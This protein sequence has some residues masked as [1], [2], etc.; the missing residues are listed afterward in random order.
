MTTTAADSTD[1]GLAA[2]VSSRL[3]VTRRDPETT[4]YQPLGFLTFN[5]HTYT[6]RYL[7]KAVIEDGFR[8]LP[9]LSDATRSH[10]SDRL[11][12]IFAERVIS[13]RRPDR[14]MS[15]TALGLPVDAAPFEVL[16]RSGGRRVGDTIEVVPAPTISPDGT[17]SIDFLVHGVR[18]QSS[19]AQERITRLR[20]GEHLRIVHQVD[21]PADRRAL[22]VTDQDALPLGYVP[23]P[24]LELVHNVTDSNAVVLRANPPKVG[25]HF[26]L[27]AR[28]TG[29]MA[30]DHQPF[31]GPDWE[32]IS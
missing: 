22:L 3:L 19:E 32:T 9:G 20:T 15:M 12:P 24:L 26:R 18:Y 13:A 2:P 27:L 1:A 7:R 17:V 30:N 31:T 25:F 10:T 21:N 14:E 6:F 23:K 4:S 8:A 29:R 11:F 16:Q 28:V 5:G